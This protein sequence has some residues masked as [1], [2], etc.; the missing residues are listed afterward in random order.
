MAILGVIL[1]ALG[2]FLNIYLLVIVGA[3]LLI[4]GLVLI[5]VPIGGARHR[6]Y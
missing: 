3:I 4:I 5:F 2:F 1:L 6:W